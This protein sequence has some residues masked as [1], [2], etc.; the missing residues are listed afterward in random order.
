VALSK[1]TKVSVGGRMLG[2]W[3]E[4]VEETIEEFCWK[5]LYLS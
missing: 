2:A 4:S 5:G 1:K 3:Q